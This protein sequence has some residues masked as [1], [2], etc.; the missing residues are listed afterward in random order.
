M[1]TVLRIFKEEDFKA[2]SNIYAQGIATGI[3]TFETEIPDW[4]K[5]NKK[6]IQSCRIVAEIDNEVI[7]FT[8]LSQASKRKA[9][10]GVAEVS[11]YVSGKYQSKGIGEELLKQLIEKS[12]ENGFWTFTSRHFFRKHRKYQFA[13]KMW[14]QTG[15]NPRKSRDVKWKMVLTTIFWKDEVVNIKTSGRFCHIEQ[16]REMRTLFK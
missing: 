4:K 6:Y 8:V 2:V 5:W 1:N 9:Y 16:S 13:F 15:W 11:V 3:A 14:F 10:I 12:E 7:G